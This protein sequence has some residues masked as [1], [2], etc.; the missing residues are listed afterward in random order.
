MKTF[1]PPIA[2]KLIATKLIAMS[3]KLKI[4]DPHFA[5][6]LTALNLKPA[7]EFDVC[8]FEPVRWER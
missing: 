1:G 3:P 2:M 6:S 5:T 4:F 7:R 8:C